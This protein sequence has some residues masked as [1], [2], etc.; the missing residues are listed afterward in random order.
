[1]PKFINNIKSK[2]IWSILFFFTSILF[3]NSQCILD[4]FANDL[5]GSKGGELKTFLDENSDGFKTWK[6][7][8]SARGS[9]SSFKTDID[10]LK[11]VSELKQSETFMQRIGGEQGLQDIIKANVRARCKSCG[12]TGAAYLKN[13]DEYLDDVKN[14]A[15]NYHDV[16]GFGDVLTDIKRINSTGSPNLNVEGAAF[17]LRVIS[18]NESV[19]INKITKFEGSIDDLTNGCKYDLQFNNGSKLSFGEFKSYKESSIGN[20]AVNGKPTYQ[21]LLTYIGKIDSID[22]LYYF[23]DIKKI[24]N[25]N[26]IKKR[27]KSIFNGNAKAIFESNEALFKKYNRLDGKGKIQDWEDFQELT[28]SENFVNHELLNFIILN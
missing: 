22:E 14:L 23:F 3:V 17:M 27:F 25:I 21:Q 2:M 4:D 19:F 10:L 7:I 9:Q 28:G 26:I 16:D 18:E 8:R 20:F 13:I 15:D 5:A 6:L 12:N 24:S 1:M 11:K